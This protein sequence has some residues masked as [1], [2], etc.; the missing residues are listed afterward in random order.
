MIQMLGRGTYKA[1]EAFDLANIKWSAL[2]ANCAGKI[3]FSLF[4]RSNLMDQMTI[5]IRNQA[6]CDVKG[7]EMENG[8]IAF[9][10]G[11][12]ESGTTITEDQIKGMEFIKGQL[13]IT[14]NPKTCPNVQ[15][16]M[17]CWESQRDHDRFRR[18][19]T[20][21]KLEDL[22]P[23]LI[24]MIDLHEDR[25]SAAEQDGKVDLKIVKKP[26]DEVKGDACYLYAMLD[27]SRTCPD[28]ERYGV[29]FVKGFVT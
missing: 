19:F 22:A 10:A 27:P 29:F 11:L 7:K 28:R 4:R 25:L 21:A 6:A 24:G 13:Q 3:T 16:A 1:S 26:M 9:N 23:Q 8:N 15:I 14:G 17:K 12:A 18:S 20:A 2:D 5:P